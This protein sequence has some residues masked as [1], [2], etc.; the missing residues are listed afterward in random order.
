MYVAT[1][2][3]SSLPCFPIPA[4]RAHS[5]VRKNCDAKLDSV[6]H[7]D[8]AGNPFS[9]T[10]SAGVAEKRLA[11]ANTEMTVKRADMALYSAKAA[12]RI[13]RARHL[14]YRWKAICAVRPIFG[15]A[16][17]HLSTSGLLTNFNSFQFITY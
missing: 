1:V 13:V 10:V 4:K 3:K 17:D 14:E 6:I 8:A 16:T 5:H 9:V 2:A 11:D 12:G 7:Y 15:I